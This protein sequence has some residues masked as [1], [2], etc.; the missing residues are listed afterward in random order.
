MNINY[1]IIASYLDPL[2]E[3]AVEYSHEM[4]EGQ[5]GEDPPLPVGVDPLG[6][7]RSRQS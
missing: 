5:R 3:E 6:A 7:D 2:M 4:R 1:R